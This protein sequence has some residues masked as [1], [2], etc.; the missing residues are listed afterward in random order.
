MRSKYPDLLR[1]TGSGEMSCSSRARTFR[2]G[3]GQTSSI[4]D[5]CR[6]GRIADGEDLAD[7]A[8]TLTRTRSSSAGRGQPLLK[9]METFF[10]HACAR[11]S[12]LEDSRAAPP[13]LLPHPLARRR[14]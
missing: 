12:A 10:A 4:P 3:P 5:A 1:V 2:S 7:F 6:P 8:Y 11:V 13:G 14:P 9:E